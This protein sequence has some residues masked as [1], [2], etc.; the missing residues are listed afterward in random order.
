MKTDVQCPRLA[1]TR[2]PIADTKLTAEQIV[3]ICRHGN[4]IDFVDPQWKGYD[5]HLSD[6]GVLQARQTGQRLRGEGIRHIFSS[7]FLR[8]VETAHHIAEAM[9]LPIKLEPGACEW[10]N[11][12]WFREVPIFATVAELRKRFPRIDESYRS[13]V[14]PRF[15]ESPEDLVIRCRETA[16]QLAESFPSPI[17]IVAHGASVRALTRGLLGDESEIGCGLCALVKVRRTNERAVLEINGDI[18]HLSSGNL[19]GNRFS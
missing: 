8:T 5:P 17:L 13:S 10:L 15:P 7:P 9:D 3:W 14:S 18:T 11:I 6:D 12:D 1:E 19:H 2:E 4:R 16:L